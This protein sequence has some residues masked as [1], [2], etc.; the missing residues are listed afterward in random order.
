VPPYCGISCM[1]CRACWSLDSR[2][3]APDP[4]IWSTSCTRVLGNHA[5]HHRADFRIQ[6]GNR[7][8]AEGRP[9]RNVVGVETITMSP[10]Q[11]SIASFKPVA[12]LAFRWCGAT[13]SQKG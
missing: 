12:C 10:V 5:S 1:L 7:Q 9:L 3:N 6:E 13:A 11:I 2:R 4:A 8:I